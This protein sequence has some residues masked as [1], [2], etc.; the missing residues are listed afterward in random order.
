M[1]VMTKRGS[2]DNVI[3]Y[4]HFC[5]AKSDLANIPKSQITLGSVAIVLNDENNSLGVYIADSSK[6]WISAMTS[7]GGSGGSTSVDLISICTSEEYDSSTG[8]PT[9]ENPEENKLY[10]VPNNG[11]NNNLFNEWIWTG[12][13]W[14][15][16][17]GA[18][19]SVSIVQSDWNQNDSTASDYIK[20]R[21]CY[22]A[23]TTRNTI[24]DDDYSLTGALYNSTYYYGINFDPEILFNQNI[25]E[26]EEAGIVLQIDEQQY[27]LNRC[28][29]SYLN[30]ISAY[31][32]IITA[33]SSSSADLYNFQLEIDTQGYLHRISWNASATVDGTH[34]ILI[35]TDNEQC[36]TIPTKY[37]PNWPYISKNEMYQ[38]IFSGTGE[39]SRALSSSFTNNASGNYS[40]SEGQSTT[41]SGCC[42]HAE[43]S[44][45]TASGTGAHAEGK[46]TTASRECDHAEGRGTIAQGYYSHA[47][48]RNSKAFGTS[49]HAEGN[50]TIANHRAQ[51]VFGECNIADTSE[52]SYS[53]RGNY[54]EIVGNG[55]EGFSLDRS[56]ARTL[57]WS[58]NEW[59]AGN[60]TAAGGSITIGSTTITEQQLQALLAL[61]S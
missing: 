9:I 18:G 14:E 52:A 45:T 48:G 19:G 32:Y 55:I 60:L 28:Y 34:H 42:S 59:L 39:Y 3:T 57:D 56:N 21:V 24:I 33:Y 5:D 47:E 11:D 37:L 53:E 50:D 23:N 36:I 54:I 44:N 7:T 30:S 38:T 41:A 10:L 1:N 16:F 13:E 43:G 61:L 58:G 46:G 27:F 8:L 49:S 2:L 4:E 15:Q 22:V 25:N 20:N 6:T 29:S 17:G 51:H 12:E 31:G 40:V 26:T 35:Y